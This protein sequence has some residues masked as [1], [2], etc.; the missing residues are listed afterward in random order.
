MRALHITTFVFTSCIIISFIVPLMLT[1]PQIPINN[2]T[3]IMTPWTE[4]NHCTH[5]LFDQATFVDNACKIWNE[6][7]NV[8]PI[9]FYF[10]MEEECDSNKQVDDATWNIHLFVTVEFVVF[11]ILLSIAIN[12]AQQC[13]ARARIL[14]YVSAALWATS[15]CFDVLGTYSYEDLNNFVYQQTYDVNGTIYPSRFVSNVTEDTHRVFFNDQQSFADR[16]CDMK[17]IFAVDKTHW[18]IVIN[19]CALKNMG[20]YKICSIV[21]KILAMC[22]LIV[23]NIMQLCEERHSQD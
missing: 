8:T 2:K 22:M 21:F 7:Q 12:Y 6:N 20:D 13:E 4:E 1:F 10:F 15:F 18:F 17:R 3:G 11:A 19:N 5:E 9:L 16:A 14:I 23:A